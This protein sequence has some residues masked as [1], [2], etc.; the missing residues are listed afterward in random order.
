M[1]RIATPYKKAQPMTET[2]TGRERALSRLRLKLAADRVRLSSNPELKLSRQY[3][4]YIERARAKP[5][6]RQR[7]A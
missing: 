6:W 1:P 4:R 3:K 2:T 5:Y 7:A